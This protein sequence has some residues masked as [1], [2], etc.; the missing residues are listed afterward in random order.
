MYVDKPFAEDGTGEAKHVETDSV[1]VN[2]ANSS[3]FVSVRDVNHVE[4]F[5]ETIGEQKEEENLITTAV[6]VE[7]EEEHEEL[8]GEENVGEEPTLLEDL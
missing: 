6:E 5:S 8:G 1:L 7:K 2:A 3:E 4:A